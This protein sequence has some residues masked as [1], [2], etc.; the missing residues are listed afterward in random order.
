LIAIA[1]TPILAWALASA[2]PTS[3]I[4]PPAPE[5]A[6]VPRRPG[7][8]LAVAASTFALGTAASFVMPVAARCTT[9]H[10][11]YPYGDD[12]SR[13]AML[14]LVATAALF[15]AAAVTTAGFAGRGYG[16]RE[17]YRAFVR[18]ERR[19]RLHAGVGIALVVI[20]GATTLG[21]A[22]L[23]MLLGRTDPYDYPMNAVRQSG[24][25]VGAGGGFL[26]GH[27]LAP[28]RRTMVVRPAISGTGIGVVLAW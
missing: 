17:A 27:A 21:S 11:D 28:R 1:C 15:D 6:L 12:C 14:G 22:L 20:G 9:P 8:L 24:V 2:P 3:S 25:L 19:R 13:G 26:L 16:R 23:P 10:A 5:P 7:A 18:P 4:P